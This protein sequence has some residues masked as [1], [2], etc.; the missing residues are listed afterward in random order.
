MTG[1]GGIWQSNNEKKHPLADFSRGGPYLTKDLTQN[2][3]GVVVPPPNAPPLPSLSNES[4]NVRH[5]KDYI[6][7]TII[8]VR[9]K[10]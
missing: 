8:F 2:G 9:E 10:Y 5:L 3:L 7:Q 1:S 4:D 6:I